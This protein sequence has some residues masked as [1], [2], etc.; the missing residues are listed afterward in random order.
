MFITYHFFIAN[1]DSSL[2]EPLKKI[3][4]FCFPLYMIL[5]EFCEKLKVGS[6]DFP[7]IKNIVTPLSSS[8]LP[9]KLIY[10]FKSGFSNSIGLLESVAINL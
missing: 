8:N 1:L 3:I 10:C 7:M 2:L 4:T 5:I 6:S 9:I